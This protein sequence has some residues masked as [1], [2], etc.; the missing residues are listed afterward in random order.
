MLQVMS[1]QVRVS[2]LS[3]EGASS[4]F[5]RP[6]LRQTLEQSQQ[7]PSPKKKKKTQ[8]KNKTLDGRLLVYIDRTCSSHVEFVHYYTVKLLFSSF[9]PSPPS[10]AYSPVWWIMNRNW[11]RGGKIENAVRIRRVEERYCCR[12]DGSRR[13]ASLLSLHRWRQRRQLPSRQKKGRRKKEKSSLST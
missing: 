9:S 7:P 4:F 8:N 3:I 2:I 13:R 6:F 12:N 11:W 10:L 1:F 5:S